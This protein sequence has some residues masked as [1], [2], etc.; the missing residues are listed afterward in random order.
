[1]ANAETIPMSNRKMTPH[2]LIGDADPLEVAPGVHYGIR[3]EDYVRIPAFNQSTLKKWLELATHDNEFSRCPARWK[4][5]FDNERN[6][7]PSKAMELGSAL[8]SWLLEDGAEF[9]NRFVVLPADA[10]NRP[11]SRQREAKKPSAATL[12]AIDWWDAFNEKC[13]GKTVL[14]AETFERVKR[15]AEALRQNSQCSEI[16][17]Y[18]RKAVVVAELA[19][20][21]VKAEYDLFEDSTQYIFDL[22]AL[23]NVTDDGFARQAIRLGYPAQAGWYLQ[24]AQALGLKKT[25]FAFLCV[26]TEKPHWVNTP[27]LTMDEPLVQAGFSRLVKAMSALADH[28]ERDDWPDYDHFRRV[29]FPGW[30]VWDAATELE[31]DQ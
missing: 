1:M 7:P 16:L 6:T 15:I 19:G 29:Q 22:K 27:S 30:A 2:F 26:E 20:F 11:T 14:D 9:H 5:W 23:A 28:I 3:R 8:D 31:R 18:C 12:D 25:D 10:P 4:H 21:P 13:E 17:Q 24:I